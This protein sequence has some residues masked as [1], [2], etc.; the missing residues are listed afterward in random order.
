MN[1]LGVCLHI[2]SYVYVQGVSFFPFSDSFF[3]AGTPECPAS[4][5]FGTG[6]KKNVNAGTSP[7]PE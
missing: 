3:H 7:V 1:L 6:M 2:A 4:D 5:H